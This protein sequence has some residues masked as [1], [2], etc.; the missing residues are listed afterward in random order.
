MSTE[1]EPCIARGSHNDRHEP[2]VVCGGDSY[3]HAAKPGPDLS[4]FDP[5]LRRRI[6]VAVA[7]GAYWE[8]GTWKVRNEEKQPDGWTLTHPAWINPRAWF[9][10]YGLAMSPEFSDPE[11]RP[12]DAWELATSE[13]SGL[14]Q[15]VSGRGWFG[16]WWDVDRGPHG[17]Q[18]ERQGPLS[19]TPGR[20]VVDAFLA[21]FRQG[22]E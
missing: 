20:A 18:V 4:A 9:D 8:R 6:D 16:T 2:S 13:L 19:D 14:R 15:A 11:N 17:G 5:G 7:R 22:G 3:A 21:K 1:T 12:A 10:F